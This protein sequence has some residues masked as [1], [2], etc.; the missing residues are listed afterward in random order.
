RHSDQVLGSELAA[1]EGY[2]RETQLRREL[3]DQAR[4]ADPWC[5]PDEDRADDRDFEQEVGELGGGDGLDRVHRALRER[6][7]NTRT[8]RSAI[9]GSTKSDEVGAGQAQGPAPAL[10]RRGLYGNSG[11]WPRTGVMQTR[12]QPSMPQG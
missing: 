1:E 8:A 6:G 5:S 7:K 10:P 3:G 9:L 4:L 12:S 2:A 11:Q